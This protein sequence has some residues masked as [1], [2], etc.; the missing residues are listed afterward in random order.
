M[1]IIAL[2]L[3]AVL[4]SATGD[5]TN[6]MVLRGLQ[7]NKGVGGYLFTM[8]DCPGRCLI[9][10]STKN[11]PQIELE[12]CKD[13]GNV[14]YWEIDDD[15]GNN[16]GFFKIRHVLQDKCIADPEDCSTCNKDI[17]LVDCNTDEAALF[18]YGDLHKKSP[19][20]YNLYS[21]RCWLNEGL[22]SVLAT[23]S[24]DA[25]TC[26]ENHASGACHRLEWNLDRF[27]SDVLYYEWSFNRVR[28]ECDVTLFRPSDLA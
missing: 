9:Y 7:N 18:S 5:D 24:L 15:C 10:N 13:S 2:L 23:P 12:S 19:K 8:A 6:S 1:K 16:E 3:C 4:C 27:S 17:D 14:K 21:A 28:A 20:A 22:I 25:K 11:V 26:P